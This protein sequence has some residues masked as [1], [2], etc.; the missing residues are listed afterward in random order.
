MWKVWAVSEGLT[1]TASSL[2]QKFV[3]FSMH[4]LEMACVFSIIIGVVQ[5]AAGF[6]GYVTK[7]FKDPAHVS[8]LVPDI[9]SVFWAILFGFFAGIFGTVLGV[10]TFVLGADIGVRTL[11]LSFSVVPGAIVGWMLWKDPL[12]LR[13]WMGISI[14][15]VA[16][17]AMLDFPQTDMFTSLPSWVWLTIVIS[18]SS[19]ANEMLSRAAGVKLDIWT[20]NF[21]VGVST[22]FFS[23]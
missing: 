8:S 12:D 7:C 9:R 10:Y 4:T 15:L 5:L 11:L 19:V 23:T 13:Q 1:K 20:N 21:W 16:V 14:F 22:V 6:M 18:L 17:W 2:L 3:G